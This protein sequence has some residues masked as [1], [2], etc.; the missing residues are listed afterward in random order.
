MGSL[1]SI[2]FYLLFVRHDIVK[3]LTFISVQSFAFSF[4]DEDV[5]LAGLRPT[6]LRE[7]FDESTSTNIRGVAYESSQTSISFFFL[8]RGKR[9]T[10]FTCGLNFHKPPKF[11]GEATWRCQYRPMYVSA[12]IRVRSKPRIHLQYC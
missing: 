9:Q 12:V 3:W 10:T 11:A 5:I 8:K 1:V 7:G 2:D 4:S 6:R